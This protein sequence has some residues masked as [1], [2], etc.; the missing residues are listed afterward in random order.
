MSLSLVS[1]W[2]LRGAIRELQ[3]LHIPFSGP[4]ITRLKNRV[5]VINESILTEPEIIA[6][7]KIGRLRG[8]NPS[9]TTAR[10]ECGAKDEEL[11]ACQ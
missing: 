3:K 10:N 2:K 1:R 5:Y 11:R 8:E 4:F 6:S 9:R 7:Y